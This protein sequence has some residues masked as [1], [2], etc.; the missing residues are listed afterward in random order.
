MNIEVNEEIE[1]EEEKKGKIIFKIL[2]I[3]S[4]VIFLIVLII[5]YAR[6]KETTSLKV[7]E[8][9]I[10]NNKIPDNFHGTK[11]VQISDIHYG[12]TVDINF[13]K[14]IIKKI[15]EIKPDILILT[16]DLLDKEIT[17]EEKQQIIEALKEIKVSID[18]YAITGEKDIENKTTWDEIINESGF[19]NIDNTEKLIYKNNNSPIII[20][21][22]EINNENIFTIYTLH[23]PDNVDNLT[24]KYDLILAGHSLNGQINIPL[25]KNLLL[26]K[27]SKKYY[28]NYYK[29]NDTDLYIS[30]GIGT[31]SFKY[32]LFN[33]PSINL[34]RLTNH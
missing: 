17:Q 23:E 19:I 12:N 24:N 8:Y 10:T 5:T 26:Q 4:I 1:I 16:G 27:G 3:I 30:S 34:Y 9:K 21:N 15:N 31:T 32:R 6:Y 33:K 29:V 20:T 22:K 2:K 28:K 13:L 11:L 7:N 18:C 25:I 14:R